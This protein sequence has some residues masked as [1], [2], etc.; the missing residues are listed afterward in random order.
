MSTLE[1]W[2]AYISHCAGESLQAPVC[3]PFW[4]WVVALA[5]LFLALIAAALAWKIVAYRIKL[6]AARR[7]ETERNRVDSA[8]IAAT[9]WDGDKAYS[10]DLGGDEIERRV[11]EAVDERR[12]TNK[13]PSPIIIEK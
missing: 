1:Q 11:R 12:A 6:A 7:A 8:A 9:S 13:P 5:T 2:F 10:A 4:T 3:R